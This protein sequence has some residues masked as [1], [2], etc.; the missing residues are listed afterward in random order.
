VTVVDL[1]ALVAWGH[2][3]S[4]PKRPTLSASMDIV[5][6]VLLGL[7]AVVVQRRPPR[8]QR[9]RP[10]PT[11][12]GPAA[13]FGFGV[14]SMATNFTSLA[15]LLPGAKDIAASSLVVIGRIVMVAGLVVL[16]TMPAWI[17]IATTRIAPGPAQRGLDALGHVISEYGRRVAVVVLAA[18]GVVLIDRGILRIVV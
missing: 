11:E 16:T 8:R 4:L 12:R 10:T 14:F 5:A 1:G 3:I 15:I 2:A 6:G 9:D 18:L 17:P 7:V 13:A